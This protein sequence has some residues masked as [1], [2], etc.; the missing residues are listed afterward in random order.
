MTTE[1]YF[2]I[3][4]TVASPSS[5]STVNHQGREASYKEIKGTDGVWYRFPI[6]AEIEEVFPVKAG[7]YLVKNQSATYR[8]LLYPFLVQRWNGANWNTSGFMDCPNPEKR[9]REEATTYLGPL[10]MDT[11]ER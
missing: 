1:R 2:Q 7:Y 3:K 11:V 6:D 5:V 10:D 9:F 4:C 8:V